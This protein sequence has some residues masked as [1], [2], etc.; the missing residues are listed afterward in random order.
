MLEGLDL[1]TD[2]VFEDLEVGRSEIFERHPALGWIRVDAHEIRFGA[3]SWRLRGCRR[4]R[5]RRMHERGLG[6]RRRH[7]RARG[8]RLEPCAARQQQERPDDER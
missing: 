8:A 6:A 1:L 3:E 5:C 4:W 2:V 7:C